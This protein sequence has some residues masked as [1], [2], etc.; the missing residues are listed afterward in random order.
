MVPNTAEILKM[1]HQN[2]KGKQKCQYIPYENCEETDKSYDS[3]MYSSAF[4]TS[5]S[6]KTPKLDAKLQ[7]GYK[8]P[9]YHR[10]LSPSG[11]RAISYTQPATWLSQLEGGQDKQPK[12]T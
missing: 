4:S 1:N 7:H 2:G 6:Q 11:A 8:A 5:P 12:L 3:D 10:S 9:S